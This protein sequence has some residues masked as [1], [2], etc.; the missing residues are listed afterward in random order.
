MQN[1]VR[2]YVNE[3]IVLEVI[4]LFPLF[5]LLGDKIISRFLFDYSANNRR[6]I[7]GWG[8]SCSVSNN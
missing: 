3:L 4:S 6:K 7:N 8:Q 1:V 5:L 2:W